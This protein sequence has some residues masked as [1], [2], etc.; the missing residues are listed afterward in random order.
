MEVILLEK[1]E[2][3]GNL[4]DKVNVRPGFA[5]NF[6]VPKGKAKYATPENLA[7][8][9]ARRSELEQAAAQSLSQA[10]ERRGALEGLEVS[11]TAKAGNEGKLFGSVGAADIAQ[12]VSETGVKLEKRELRLPTGPL[13]VVGEYDIE[14]HLHSDVNTTI[15]VIIVPE[16]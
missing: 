14:V 15:K 2:N 10:E 5:R 13:R 8:F 4:G 6:L 3:L 12:A 11:I 7:E 9:E 1:I 16:A